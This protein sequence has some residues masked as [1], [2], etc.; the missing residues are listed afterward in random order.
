MDSPTDVG[1][2]QLIWNFMHPSIKLPRPLLSSAPQPFHTLP[3]PYFSGA[4]VLNSN[5]FFSKFTSVWRDL[6]PIFFLLLAC[7][8]SWLPSSL[9]RICSSASAFPIQMN[10]CYSFNASCIADFTTAHWLL[11]ENN[12]RLF[13][14][15]LFYFSVWK[16]CCTPRSWQKGLCL[17]DLLSGTPQPTAQR[18]VETRKTR[19]KWRHNWPIKNN[20]KNNPMCLQL[21]IV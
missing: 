17:S 11:L 15:C 21:Y 5:G 14:L 13:F 3:F 4:Y 10:I 8:E 12:L 19:G 2:L 7:W 20:N 9:S 16:G 6:S 1:F 18:L